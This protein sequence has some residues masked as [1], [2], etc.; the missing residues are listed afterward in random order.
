VEA[1]IKNMSSLDRDFPV[2]S[3]CKELWSP[4]LYI[5]IIKFIICLSNQK[6]QFHEYQLRKT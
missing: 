6:F 4:F 1:R 3:T 2:K 5:N